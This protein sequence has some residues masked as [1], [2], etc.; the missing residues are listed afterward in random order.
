MTLD[1]YTGRIFA[2][3]VSTTAKMLW[4]ALT[5]CA[6][7]QNTSTPCVSSAALQAMCSVSVNTVTTR[8]K[9][10]V[11][12]GHLVVSPRG[13]LGSTYE[14]VGFAPLT[15]FVNHTHRICESHSQNL[16]V[17]LTEF[18]SGDCGT[19]SATC[20]P[21]PY[22]KTTT[23]VVVVEEAHEDT[24]PPSQP[25]LPNPYL[26]DAPPLDVLISETVE[27]AHGQAPSNAGA[28]SMAL[29]SMIRIELGKH[30]ADTSTAG[31]VARMWV[32]HQIGQ[33]ADWA[34]KN[35]RSA[36]R[37]AALLTEAQDLALFVAQLMAPAPAAPTYDTRPGEDERSK[38]MRKVAS[39]LHDATHKALEA[40]ARVKRPSK[41]VAI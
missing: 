38:H 2:C 7:T 6:T 30:A 41:K 33:R 13:H 11:D 18:G 15:E 25:T 12:A 4:L 20:A 24:P 39:D 16:G 36:N 34:A 29:L 21:D 32:G 27:Q 3:S 35:E 26:D 17:S 8:V 5:Q 28:L 31:D 22:E 23:K 40:R 9:E 19:V 1:E 10:L 14:L 37:L